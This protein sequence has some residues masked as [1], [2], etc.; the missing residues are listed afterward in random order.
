MISLKRPLFEA[1]LAQ[2][3]RI[4]VTAILSP[5]LDL[6]SEHLRSDGVLLEYGDNMPTPIPDLEVTDEG[7][8]ATLSFERQPRKTFVP[9]SSVIRMHVY[10]DVMATFPIDVDAIAEKPKKPTLKA[11]Q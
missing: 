10:G 1:A 3:H 8:S 4:M 7:I 11:V 5:G 6:P 2:G 9:W